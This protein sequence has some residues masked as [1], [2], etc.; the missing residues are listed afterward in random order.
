MPDP[1]VYQLPVKDEDA[2]HPVASAWRSALCAIVRAF[3]A[4]DYA[5]ARG[6]E[7]VSPVSPDTARQ[8]EAYIAGYGET[9]AEL[10]EETWRTS[11]A[12]WM[13]PHWQVFVDLWTAESG[14]S[15]MVLDVNVF[16]VGKSFRV[17]IHL[18]YVP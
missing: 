10:P 11:V 5:L 12:Q 9:L 14:C 2:A 8:I 16:E 6:I 7:H 17:E 1:S 13:G 4:G 15:D 18:V 3:V